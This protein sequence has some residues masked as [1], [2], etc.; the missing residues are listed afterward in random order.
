[1]DERQEVIGL[2]K[3][4]LE[5]YFCRGEVE[6]LISTFSDDIVWVGGGRRHTA[7]GKEAV[8]AWFREGQ[9]DVTPCR[10]TEEVYEYRK[11]TEGCYL[12]EARSDIHSEDGAEV[13]LDMHQRCTFVFRREGDALKTVHIHNSLPYEALE[14]DELFPDQYGKK[15]YQRLLNEYER[16][17]EK[18]LRD[19]ELVYLAMKDTTICDYSYDPVRKCIDI[20][21]YMA[22][23]Y[24]WDPHYEGMPESFAAAYIDEATR[25]DFCR[26]YEAMDRGESFAT[27]EFHVK[28]TDTW[29][30]NSMSRVE[31]M[32]GGASQI[33]VGIVE[34]ISLAKR[35]ENIYSR[36]ITALGEIYFGNYYVDGKKDHYRAVKQLKGIDAYIPE[37]GTY[38]EMIRRYIQ[39]FVYKDDQARM[40]ERLELGYIMNHLNRDSRSYAIEYR[41]IVNQNIYWYRLQVIFMDEEEGRVR[42]FFFAFQNIDE[43]YK[44][45]ELRDNSLELLRDAYYR[46]SCVD[47]GNNSMTTIKQFNGEVDEV[48]R[49]SEDYRGTILYMSEN[50][51]FP[52]DQEA[53]KNI[54]MPENLK[55]VFDRGARYVDITYQR[56]IRGEYRWVRSELVPMGSYTEASPRVMWYVKNISEEKAR[57]TELSRQLLKSNAELQL[58]LQTEEQYRQAILSEAVVAYQINVSRD[59]LEQ[60]I[61]QRI[62]GQ[63]IPVLSRIGMQPPCSYEDFCRRWS[64]FVTEDTKE[65]YMQ[66]ASCR[67]L[68]Q[69]FEA[70][71]RELTLEYKSKDIRGEDIFVRQTLLLTRSEPSGDILGLCFAKDITELR[72]R[73]SETRKALQEA[74]EAANRANQAK[75]EFLSHMSHDIRTPMNGIIGM[76]AIAENS[77][78]DKERL[79]DCLR[80]ISVSSRHL[81]SLINDVLDMSKIESGKMD[82]TEEEINLCDL[83]DT[84]LAMVR[85]SAQEKGHEL[86]IHIG[87]IRHER[88]VG[89]SLRIQQAFMNI[90]SNAI[91]YTPEG[92]RIRLLISEKEGAEV[93]SGRTRVGCYEF[94]FE[95]N[96]IGMEP[97]FLNHIFEP[98][99]RAEDTSVR[100][101]QGTGLGM[102]ITRNIVR[103]M[104]GDIR[105]ESTP[106]KGS[107]FIVTIYLKVQEEAPACELEGLRLLVADDDKEACESACHILD[108]LWM[109]SRG[110]T[111]GREALKE[112]RKASEEGQ[113]YFGVLLDWHMPEMDGIQA[114]E[115]IRQAAGEGLR[116]ILTSAYDWSDMEGEAQ[117]AGADAFISKPLFRS[118]LIHLFKN[119]LSAGQEEGKTAME[120]VERF[121]FQGK[122]VLVA[123][124]NELNM[125]IATEIL[126]AAGLEVE[127]AADGKEALTKAKESERGYYDL[128]FMDIQMPVMNG[129]E[130]AAA[131]RGLG[132]PDMEQ[133]PIIAMSANA[134]AEDVQKSRE[135]GMNEHIPKPIDLDQLMRTLKH[136]LGTGRH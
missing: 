127:Q 11:L 22:A 80:K 29:I 15:R 65:A 131:I 21:D 82:L 30:R 109:I 122:R 68:L 55:R 93:P 61:I 98:F 39:W 72:Q 6:Y 136:W 96:G 66:M 94:I 84:L 125:E 52:T 20:P 77:L 103:M 5:S 76:T 69:A 75:S 64:A 121:D 44:E 126:K 37:E 120:Q 49:R 53:F 34:D 134:F 40:T 74:F 83:I 14:E 26:M 63:D 135:A 112:I 7:E 13:F 79:R 35:T 87:Q 54:M 115:A 89:D 102:A 124:D 43:E 95:D 60:E 133:I 46:I 117:R 111:S 1:M 73:E 116:I 97:E 59:L 50:I 100:Q 62:D 32:E 78:E 3:R 48:I 67:P 18:N 57:E 2:A 108:S 36:M 110:V 33:V 105:V 24:G 113:P 90:M 31:P 16:Q 91:K 123:E 4:I 25:D 104:D 47:L 118:R 41:R 88:I 132:R 129:Y 38:S 99:I 19:S 114:A 101:I 119:I 106:G 58:S 12:C 92:G 85:P 70:G 128:I 27:C 10:M 86:E 8:A 42:H 17:K 107:R 56:K 71:K 9:K 23:R 130:A 51:V 81:L 28:G 45:K